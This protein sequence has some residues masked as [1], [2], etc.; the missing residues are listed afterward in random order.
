MRTTMKMTNDGDG[1]LPPV[2]DALSH[3]SVLED[4]TLVRSQLAARGKQELMGQVR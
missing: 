4:A 3:F 1:G 2:N